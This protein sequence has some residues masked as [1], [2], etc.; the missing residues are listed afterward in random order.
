MQVTRAEFGAGRN[1]ALVA[2]LK[3]HVLQRLDVVMIAFDE[4]EQRNVI[5]RP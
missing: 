5:A 4:G 3:P 2:H 1:M